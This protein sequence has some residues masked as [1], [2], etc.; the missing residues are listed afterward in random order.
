LTVRYQITPELY[1][2]TDMN[3][4]KPQSVEA[5]EGQK[6]IP[7]A[8]TFTSIGGLTYKG[9]SGLSANLSYRLLSDRA[10]NEDNSVTAEGYFLIDAVLGYTVGTFDFGLSI[11]NVLNTE[12]RE[13]QFETESRLQ[14]ETVSVSEIHFTP[15]TP[16]QAR[17]SVSYKF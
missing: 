2:N 12:W 10:A 17:L 8:P 6:F 14:N 7:L 5:A 1:A 13:A 15:G 4:T 9:K 11:E 3:F 16:F